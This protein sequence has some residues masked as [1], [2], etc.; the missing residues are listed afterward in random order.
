MELSDEGIDFIAKEEGVRN[1]WYQDALGVWTIGI[2]HVWNPETDEDRDLTDDEV[3]D[4]FRVDVARYVHSVNQSVKRPLTQTQFDRLVS[5]AFNWG[6]SP[7]TGFPAT[8]VVQLLNAGDFV[9]AARE[10][11]DGHGPSG[12]PYD[13]GL[14]GVRNRRIREAEPFRTAGGT[15]M[16]PAGIISVAMADPVLAGVEIV[17]VNGWRDRGRPYAFE[18]QGC[19]I[20]HTATS[21]RAAGDYPSLGIV[22]DGRSD[23]P[24]PLS[25]FGLGR[26][27]AVYVIAAGTANH[28]GPGGWRGLSGNTTVWGIEAENDGIGEPWS[29]EAL[30]AYPRLVAALARHTPFGPEMVCCHREWSEYKID[31]TGIDGDEFRSTVAELLAGNTNPHPEGDLHMLTFRYIA[32]GLDWVFDGPSKLFFQLDAVE[33]ITE[34][35]DPLGVKALGK[36]S[37]VTHKRYSEIA[38]AAG[39]S[40]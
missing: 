32:E 25:Q 7:T 21:R 13:K 9:G 2:G 36:V 10:L 20:H 14:E 23:L 38:A 35:L 19:V 29:A 11:V 1:A 16:D 34:V 40:G 12:R 37:D 30:Y 5:F 33:Q 39:F 6:I 3:W 22:R 17:Y 15:P 31:P 26:S 28:A 24:G 4:L 27:G 8:S 18:P